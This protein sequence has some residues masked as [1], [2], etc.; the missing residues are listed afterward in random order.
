MP[1][2]THSKMDS[3]PSTPWTPQTR[4]PVALRVY[5]LLGTNYDD[6]STRA[7]LRTLSE[8]YPPSIPQTSTAEHP[9]RTIDHDE[10]ADEDGLSALRPVTVAD[11]AYEQSLVQ[12]R[13]GFRQDMEAQLISCSQQYLKQ[14]GAVNQVRA[15]SVAAAAVIG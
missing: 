12:A 7:A 9:P 10:D 3:Q 2:Q 1:Y 4:N 6:P 14:F 11:S 5:K 15:V 13:K 8:I